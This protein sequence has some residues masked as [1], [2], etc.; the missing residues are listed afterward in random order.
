MDAKTREE[1]IKEKRSTTVEN[2]DFNIVWEDQPS[3]LWG[4]ILSTLHLNFTWYKI[5]KDELMV[6]KGFLVDIQIR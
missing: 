6:T 4:T 2:P 5:S 3:G 1:T